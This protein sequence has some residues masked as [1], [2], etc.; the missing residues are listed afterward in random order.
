MIYMVGGSRGYLERDRVR[1]WVKSLNPSTI[2]IHGNCENSPDVWAGQM[3]KEAGMVVGEFPYIKC[4]GKMGGHVRNRAMVD[5][6][7]KCFFFWDMKSQ[8]TGKTIQY[9]MEKGKAYQVNP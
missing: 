2:L 6:A 8:G 4:F 5:I 1:N 9:A 7:D 3:A